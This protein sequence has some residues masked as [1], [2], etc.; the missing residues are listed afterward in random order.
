MSGELTYEVY[1]KKSFAVRGDR[2]K[3]TKIIKNL[4]GRWNSRMRGGPGW[5][6]PIEREA[7]L[8]KL[9]AEFG[10]DTN[11]DVPKGQTSK[12]T[13]EEIQTHVKSRKG[14]KK[15]HRAVSETVTDSDSEEDNPGKPAVSVSSASSVTE[16]DDEEEK[17][18][19]VVKKD[20]PKSE[21]VDK[22]IFEEIDRKQKEEERKRFEEEKEKFERNRTKALSREENP[23]DK[24]YKRVKR[25]SSSESDDER[26]DRSRDRCDDRYREPVRDDR[27]SHPRDRRV[28]R[29]NREDDSRDERRYRDRRDRRVDSRSRDRNRRERDVSYYKKFAEKPSRYRDM[30]E[31]S[32]DSRSSS[33][34]SSSS[35]SSSSSSDDFPLP[36]TPRG[37][38]KEYSQIYTKMRDITKQLRNEKRRR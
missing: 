11:V 13:I 36:E 14:Q 7:D 31:P 2:Q 3:F 16:T 4:N 32:D 12:G 5:L 37:R 24:G 35:R 30:Y 34:F 19:P 6:V 38:E 29:K 20:K 25:V 8:K 33:S 23:R 1:N 22:S 21:K 26:D 17:V 28:E 15:F 18:V 10:G 27:E 9:V